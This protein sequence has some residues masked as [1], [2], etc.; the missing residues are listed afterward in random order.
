MRV[1]DEAR[2]GRP[3]LICA[4]RFLR[5]GFASVVP[6]VGE[7]H[8]TGIASRTVTAS[9]ERYRC[10]LDGVAYAVTTR[11][12]GDRSRDFLAR[13]TIHALAGGSPDYARSLRFERLGPCPDGWRTG[14][15]TNQ[16]GRRLGATA[17]SSDDPR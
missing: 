1:V 13:S 4:D 11:V 12:S 5:A 17:W 14:D 10:S 8:C 7:R 16:A 6:G 15:T 3:V 2:G 9:G